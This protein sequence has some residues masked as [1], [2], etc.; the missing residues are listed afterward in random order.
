M[1]KVNYRLEDNPLLSSEQLEALQRVHSHAYRSPSVKNYLAA[2]WNQDSEPV[3]E[4]K[5]EELLDSVGITAAHKPRNVADINQLFEK[6]TYFIKDIDSGV[7]IDKHIEHGFSISWK[8][9]ARPNDWV[10][11]GKYLEP[12]RTK[13]EIEAATKMEKTSGAPFFTKKGEVFH[14]VYDD[15][16][17]NIIPNNRELPP[18]TAYCRTAEENKTRLVFA[19]S[20]A[21]I[22]LES[23]FARPLIQHFLEHKNAMTIGM[24]NQQLGDKLSATMTKR[25]VYT[26]DYSKYDMTICRQF[27]L[28]AFQILGSWFR[29]EDREALNWDKMVNQFIYGGLILPDGKVYY[30]KDHG[31]GSGS[32]FTQLID[33]VVNIAIIMAASH[34]FG[35]HLNANAVF[36][37]GDDSIFCS[38]TWLNPIEISNWVEKQYG[39]IIHPKKSE[40]IDTNVCRVFHF[41][42]KYWYL[43]VPH[44][45]EEELYSRMISPE[46]FR[47]LSFKDE[48]SAR[49]SCQQLETV[50]KA[51]CADCDEGMK[52]ASVLHIDVFKKMSKTK[53]LNSKGNLPGLTQFKLETL[54]NKQA[55]EDGM[56]S[57]GLVGM[58]AK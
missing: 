52:L 46:R 14:L 16:M 9:F 43:G 53:L 33:S 12:L 50:V 25:Y 22:I 20:L 24:W 28:K 51:Y 13:E 26:F 3:K 42:G 8:I 30:G 47:R 40:I 54:P 38:F 56:F 17:N 57:M 6:Y 10:R 27:I 35:L 41:L 39:I 7:K 36:V 19:Q 49:E 1:A 2:I 21:T 11:D 44:R 37:L 32:Y 48:E 15:L 5:I 18:A 58:Y 34:K 45:P 23:Q 4:K 31:V 55:H 29:P